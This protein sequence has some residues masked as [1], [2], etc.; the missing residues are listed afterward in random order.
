MNKE[1]RHIA[2]LGSTGS[3]GTQAL[4]VIRAN[5][6][7]FVA[8]VLTAQSN[9][10]LLIQQALEFNPNAVVIG[11]ESKYALVKEAL[12]NTDTK[13]FAGAAALEQVV[14]FESI[15]CVLTALVGF[16]GLK[17]T[18][19]AINAGKP[20]A[21]ANKETLVV[22]G[23]LVTQLAQEKGVN[24]LPV[25]SEHSAIFQC[26]VGEFHNPIEKIIL[27]ASGGPFRGKDA[28]F[29]ASV[30]KE[31][32]LKH[33]NWDMGAKI[34]IDSATLMNKGLEVIEAKWLFYLKPEQIDVVVHPQ[35]II[36]SMVQFTDG[37][38]K[39]QMGL[40][41]M[42][43]PIQFA[44]AYPHR[45]KSDFP[46]FNFA[47]YPSLTFEQPD[48]ETFKCLNL[49]FDALHKGGNMACILNAANEVAVAAFLQDKIGFLQIP[50]L[51]A[52]CMAKGTF[53]EKPTLTDYLETDAETRTFAAQ[54][55]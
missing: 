44:L 36:H 6:H 24:I 10:G 11:D 17:P 26:L 46:R 30:T 18:I 13:V 19:A 22:A 51:L 50:E 49:A 9:A 1:K 20:I 43:L 7:I 16:A 15:D 32:A 34:T 45:I 39:A 5:P 12:T 54:L 35:S 38:I 21:L 29:L 48:L 25:D 28:A 14:E 27:T 2:I 31:Q 52:N 41:D 33:P 55:I 40:P 4:D 53:V 8:E 37:S 42:K 23:Q 3:I 47:N